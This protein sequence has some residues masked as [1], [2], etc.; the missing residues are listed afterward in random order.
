ML[1]D[2]KEVTVVDPTHFDAVVRRCQ[3]VR[4]FVQIE[5]QPDE[6]ARRINMKITGAGSQRGRFTA[7]ADIVPALAIDHSAERRAVMRGPVARWAARSTRRRR[8]SS[9][10]RLRTCASC[11]RSTQGGLI[12]TRQ[13]RVLIFDT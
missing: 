6:A 1:P 7:G 11:R 3:P 8:S 9:R 2:V 13:G 12:L 5:L 4:K 10:R